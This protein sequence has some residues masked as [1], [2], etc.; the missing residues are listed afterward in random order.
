MKKALILLLFL[1][2]NLTYYKNL[3][4]QELPVTIIGTIEGLEYDDNFKPQKTQ[5]IVYIP[6]ESNQ[7]EKELL[8]YV[9]GVVKLSGKLTV[10]E[11]EQS[12][13]ITK[14]EKVLVD[15]N[16]KDKEISEYE[17][18]DSNDSNSDN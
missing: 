17:M 14:I 7:Q 5:L 18:D 11:S 3:I 16:L 9:D 10:N 2:I 6:I 15:P 8:K 13:K 1:S 12:L 4:A